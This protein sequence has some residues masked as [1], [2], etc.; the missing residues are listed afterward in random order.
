MEKP[1][2]VKDNFT[3]LARNLDVPVTC[4]IRL[5]AEPRR[6]AD[7]VRTIAGTGVAALGV[8]GRRREQRPRDPASWEGIRQAVEA[9][10]GLPVIANGDVFS[11]SDVARVRRAT[12]AAAVMIARGAQ[13]NPSIFRPAGFLPLE[14]VKKVSTCGRRA[15]RS[16][17]LTST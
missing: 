5:L 3:T 16:G 8:H 1:E 2:T 17:G 13:W 6:T 14:E 9:V 12:G 4:K 10:P 15:G 11:Y 7:L